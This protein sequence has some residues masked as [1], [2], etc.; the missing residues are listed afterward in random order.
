MASKRQEL[1]KQR[2]E[3][4]D[5]MI[6]DLSVPTELSGD[7]ADQAAQVE[8]ADVT[9]PTTADTEMAAP[10]DDQGVDTVDAPPQDPAAN[11]GESEALRVEVTRLAGELAAA[12][13]RYSTLQGMINARNQDIAEL[14]GVIASLN[15][16]PVASAPEP[17]P[18]VSPKDIEEYG[19][20]LIDLIK[21]VTR[22]EVS[23]LLQNVDAKVD[24]VAR[25]ATAS[26]EQRFESELSRA[27]PDWESVNADPE[28][29]VWLGKYNVK[30][31]NEAYS[32]MDVEGTAKYF[33]DYKK[34]TAPVAPPEPQLSLVPSAPPAPAASDALEQLAA[35]AKGK[36]SPAPVDAYAGK[37]W[38]AS[39]ITKL[40]RD[41][42][43]KRINAAEFN[44]LE[45]D[46]FKAQRDGR[47]AA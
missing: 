4:A 32:S 8:A 24:N 39:E 27:V 36:S 40:Y 25:V 33:L 5:R 31:L 19:S 34:L 45:A 41:Y 37:V 47:V 13:A 20:E 9:P 21:R 35:P 18:T 44:K 38:A 7:S 26:A 17:A 1:I 46:L 22:G 43:E 3:E 23:P 29:V 16:Q 11:G 2:A 42:A 30:A 28:F 14:R 10:L 12:N 6:A 15:A